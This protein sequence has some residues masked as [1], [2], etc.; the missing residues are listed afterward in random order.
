MPS[1]STVRLAN[2]LKFSFWKVPWALRGRWQ[3]RSPVCFGGIWNVEFSI[4]L[5]R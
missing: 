1:L 3:A 4:Y 5:Q 2:A